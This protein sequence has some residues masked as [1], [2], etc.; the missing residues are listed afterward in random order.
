MELEGF[1]TLIPIFESLFALG[2]IDGGARTTAQ[3]AIGA[4]NTNKEKT[5]P[6]YH[7]GG[8]QK[9]R[10]G[11]VHEKNEFQNSC[12]I[13]YLEHQISMNLQLFNLSINK[14]SETH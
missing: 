7:N 2:S 8:D 13:H 3:T 5:S 4:K 6:Q 11:F 10:K 9:E 14:N 12:V 1:L